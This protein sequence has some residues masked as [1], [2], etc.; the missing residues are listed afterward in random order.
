MQIFKGT[1]KAV[2]PRLRWEQLA[3]TGT[4][5]LCATSVPEPERVSP[6]R[7]ALRCTDEELGGLFVLD[8]GS[9]S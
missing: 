5:C 3:P 2:R 8:T 1:N 9:F 6:S 4:R 7:A